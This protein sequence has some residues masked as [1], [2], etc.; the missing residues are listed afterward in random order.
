VPPSALQKRIIE[1]SSRLVATDDANQFEYLAA[2]LKQ[3]LH[4]HATYLQVS[5]DNTRK[6]IV[7]A[8]ATKSSGDK[9]I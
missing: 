9:S 1:L 3:A 5:I 4:E 2:E 7:M 8:A 6:H